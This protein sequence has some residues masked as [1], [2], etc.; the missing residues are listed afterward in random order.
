MDSFDI[1]SYFALTLNAEF[2]EINI[3]KSTTST[4][5][6]FFLLNIYFLR[7]HDE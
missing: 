1:T 2:H 3:L 5:Q 4:S 7:S 6:S